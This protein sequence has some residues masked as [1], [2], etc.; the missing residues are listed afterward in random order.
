MKHS[1]TRHGRR[2]GFDSGLLHGVPP[3]TPL[4][5]NPHVTRSELDLNTHPVPSSSALKAA[6]LGVG[7]NNAFGFVQLHARGF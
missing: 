2:K 5:I 7:H 4:H 6:G 1:N 3:G